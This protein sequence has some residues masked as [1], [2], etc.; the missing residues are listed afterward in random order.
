MPDK[1]AAVKVSQRRL[2]TR[3]DD[4]SSFFDDWFPS[5]GRGAAVEHW[6]PKVD[7]L[8]REGKFVIKADLPGVNQA[9]IN[10]SLQG[11]TLVLEAHRSSEK[12]TKNEDYY[13]CEREEGSYQRAIQLPPGVETDTIEATYKDGVVEITAEIPQRT[14]AK[15]IQ[16]KGSKA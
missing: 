10:V 3:F 5:R 4:F 8:E 14:N 7:V 6:A 1:S 15:K 16:V 9:D 13:Q 2:P 12:E 11:N